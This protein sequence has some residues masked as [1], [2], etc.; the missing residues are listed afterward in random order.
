MD[1]DQ[2]RSRIHTGVWSL[3]FSRLDPLVD[4]IGL[5]SACCGQAE[6]QEIE[7]QAGVAVPAFNKA[8]IEQLA[9]M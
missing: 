7:A 5:Q 8:L 2:S 4:I 1:R 9:R 3:A 6:Q